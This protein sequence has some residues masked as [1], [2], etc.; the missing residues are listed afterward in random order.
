MAGLIEDDLHEGEVI[1]QSISMVLPFHGHA[2]Y[3]HSSLICT[4]AC[5]AF[6]TSQKENTG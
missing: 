3:L 2:S 1:I 5:K 6:N 4:G